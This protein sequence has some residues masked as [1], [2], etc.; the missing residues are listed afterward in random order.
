MKD[1]PRRLTIRRRL[2]SREFGPLLTEDRPEPG[3]ANHCTLVP[4]IILG[5]QARHR[6]KDQPL[7]FVCV[8]R[9]DTRRLLFNGLNGCSAS[10]KKV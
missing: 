10:W 4:D 3:A 8:P 5:A 6:G 7:K 1:P 9:T 2:G